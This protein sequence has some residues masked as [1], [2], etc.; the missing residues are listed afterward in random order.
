MTHIMRGIGRGHVRHWIV[1][2]PIAAMV[3]VTIATAIASPQPSPPG[4]GQGE[5]ARGPQAVPRLTT[6]AVVTRTLAGGQAHR[7]DLLLAADQ[8]V[9]VIVTPRDMDVV[10]TLAGPGARGSA[11]ASAS[12]GAGS[13]AAAPLRVDLSSDLMMSERIVAIADTAGRHRI[14]VLSPNARARASR[15]TL[16]VEA[17]R[18][19]TDR[20]RAWVRA[21]RTLEQGARLRS[22]DGIARGSSAEAQPTIEAALAGLR[23][24]DDRAGAADALFLLAGLALERATA[25]T[26]DRAR[27]AL[28]AYRGLPDTTGMSKAF[29]VLGQAHERRGELPAAAE[30]MSQ[31]L[32]L[33]QEIGSAAIEAR[34]RLSLSVL[35]GRG[36]DA[37]RGIGQSREALR[38]FR[39]LG[40]RPS[41]AFA[42][43]NMGLAARDLG[44]DQLAL[45]YYEE[46]LRIGRAVGEKGIEANLLNN[47]GNLYRET[48]QYEKAL[49]SHADAL[50]LARAVKNEDNEA[51]AL[52]TLG[53]TWRRLGEH[54]KALEYQEQSLAIRRRR[55][56]DQAAIASTLDG[57]GRTWHAL[58]DDTRALAALNE[59]LEIRHR[60]GD[61]YSETD[62]LRQLAYVERDRGNLDAARGHVEASVA[63]TDTLRR[64]MFSP[65]LRASY[66]AAQ[67]EQ[68]ELHVD[69]LMQLHQQRP[70]EGFL[71][72]ALEASERGRARVLLE[73][74]D[75]ALK[76]DDPA[77]RDDPRLAL[78][79]QPRML[80][81]TAIQRELL[82]RD[83]ILLEFTLGEGRSWLWTVGTDTLAGFELPP[84]AAIE[85][86]AR[87]LYA[88]LTAR[89]PRA[90]ESLRDRTTR[91]VEADAAWR[92]EAAAFSRTLFGPAVAH[93][94][95]AWRGKRLLIVGAGVLE[96][97][98]FS[99]LPEPAA[100][101][102]L[103]VPLVADH[104]IVSLPSASVLA[105]MRQENGARPAPPKQL[106]VLADP[107]FEIADPRVR[108]AGRAANRSA[109]VSR[110]VASRGASPADQ[111]TRSTGSAPTGRPS[112]PTGD[113]A[114][115]ATPAARPTPATDAPPVATGRPA[116]LQRLARLPFSR[117]EA[118]AIAA[119]VPADG[120]LQAIDFQ[121]SRALATSAALGEYRIV[122]F[123]THGWFDSERPDQS[124][125]VFSLVGHDGAAQDG[126]LR[127]RDIYTLRLPA[128]V[129]V[130][131]ACQTALGKEIKGEGLIGL[132]RG[133]MHAGARRVVA[134]LWQVDDLAT[135]ELMRLFYRGMLQEGLR[136]AAALRAAQRELSTQARWASPY[137]WSAFVLQGEWR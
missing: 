64:T 56:G 69:V 132:T 35:Y 117:Q 49:A 29:Q 137:Y 48:G 50:T 87:R 88:L 42:L 58:G 18:P 2:P 116:G 99:A 131:S 97:L 128:D 27:A 84:R 21:R 136:P 57:M 129:V 89:Q 28:E 103:L 130:L 63:L 60:I 119:F 10:V 83:T 66:V 67:Q 39:A 44:D 31:A 19:A 70:G 11:G 54:R 118:Q 105:V 43:N 6:G 20:D 113:Q 55:S 134:S 81:T 114:A 121:A 32:A 17:I 96:Y 101:T 100:A 90:A 135:A 123:A 72:R 111:V 65:D 61:R 53:M 5:G 8:L 38:L 14:E 33:A 133:F 86:A 71:A 52:N 22:P 77:R 23:D 124:G 46:A 94:G 25:D 16:R 59:A 30:A 62:T 1:G 3:A 51:R 122:H 13:T 109:A 24:A 104:E 74:L 7:Y 75:P 26:V 93:L 41:E 98:P 73:S 15:Y 79:T 45:T 9:D 127:L 76:L 37:E 115:T 4:R 126:V 102:A 82:D 91:L 80:T 34:T 95:E 110:G 85:A 92:T 36:G 68:Y 12:A 40:M 125:L 47:L 108:T 107:V 106:A 120:R 112:Q 78:L